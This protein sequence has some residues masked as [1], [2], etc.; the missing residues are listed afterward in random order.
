VIRVTNH[1]LERWG[2]RSA[3]PRLPPAIA[4]EQA[5]SV[6]CGALEGDEFRY[7]EWS[8]TVLIRKG[9]G[10][11]TVIDAAT[12]RPRIRQAVASVGGRSA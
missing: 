12:A 8:E 11:V 3:Q 4:W 6:D 1:A 5:Q 2:Q 7:H 9:S 10:L